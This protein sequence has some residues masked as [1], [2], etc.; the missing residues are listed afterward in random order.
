[1]RFNPVPGGLTHDHDASG[2]AIQVGCIARGNALD[3]L[4]P[5]PFVRHSGFILSG[6]VD[7]SGV[8]PGAYRG[9]LLA[10]LAR[11]CG[12]R[13]SCVELSEP[14]GIVLNWALACSLL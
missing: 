14:G 9:R 7:V 10:A 4:Q 8:G 13:A 1:M 6:M 11:S 3:G 12:A 5:G 2:A